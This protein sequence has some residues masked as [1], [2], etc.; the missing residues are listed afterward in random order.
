MFSSSLGRPIH[1][2]ERHRRGEQA[3]ALRPPG[4]RP[5]EIEGV[6]LNV[7]SLVAGLDTRHPALKI[8][9]FGRIGIDR[10]AAPSAIAQGQAEGR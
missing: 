5:A 1:F 7:L 10:L 6:E 4:E 2:S 3:P 9:A 8:P